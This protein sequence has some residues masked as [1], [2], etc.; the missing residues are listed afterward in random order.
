MLATKGYIKLE[1]VFAQIKGNQG[2][3]RFLLWGTAKVSAEWGL[4]ALG[5]KLYCVLG[6]STSGFVQI[7][8]Q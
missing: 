6:L 1:T 7:L 2:Y 3:R 4:L 8:Y 5:Y